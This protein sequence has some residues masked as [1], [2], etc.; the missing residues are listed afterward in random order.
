M[1]KAIALI[2][3]VAVASLSGCAQTG[4]FAAGHLTSVE[5]SEPNYRVVATGISGDAR[6]AYLLGVSYSTGPSTGSPCRITTS[7]SRRS[8]SV[9]QA[10]AEAASEAA[11]VKENPR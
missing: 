10:I 1:R 5:L 8:S 4:F 6:A 7:G 2:A 9:C 11:S 3:I